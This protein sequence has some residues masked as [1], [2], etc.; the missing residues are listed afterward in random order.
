MPTIRLRID[1]PAE[2]LEIL[3]AELADI[4][5]EAFEE[6]ERAL[7]AYAPATVWGEEPRRSLMTW[8]ESTGE[9]FA[10]GEEVIPDENWNARWEASL[11]PVRVGPF[12]ITPSWHRP[13]G[14]A[15]GRIAIVVD[16]KMSFGT[17]YHAS[18]RLALTLLAGLVRGGEAVLDAGCG[19]GILALAALKLGARHAIGF[20]VDAWARV[21]AEENAAANGLAGRLEVRLGSLETVDDSEFD[22]VLANINRNVLL[23]M[24]AGFRD[25]LR[26]G[27]ALV[28]SGLLAADRDRMLLEANRC[29]LHLLDE[30]TEE[31]W[32]AAAFEMTGSGEQIY[33]GDGRV[34][35]GASKPRPPA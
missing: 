5:F 30:A 24:M 26:A 9:P 28:V 13:A 7:V 15:A 11:E 3:V 12:L 21:N 4:G 10:L 1:A 31:G 16:P 23:D 32:W 34:R 27:G 25:R 14:D 2:T 18:T 22:L 20:D 29:A 19:T 17:G 8:L 33:T 6:H 35:S